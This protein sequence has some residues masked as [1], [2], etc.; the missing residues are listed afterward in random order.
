[1]ASLTAQLGRREAEAVNMK[2][3]L[4]VKVDELARAEK[5]KVAA[6]SEAAALDDA[7]RVCRS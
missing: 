4:S 6:I 3:E 1:M 7:L 2:G 5:G